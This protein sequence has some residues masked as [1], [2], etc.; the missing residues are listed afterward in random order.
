MFKT[1]MLSYQNWA[2]GEPD[3]SL[4]EW[5]GG[6]CAAQID[7]EYDLWITKRCGERGR[8]GT[9]CEKLRGNECPQGWTF[10]ASTDGPLCYEFILNGASYKAE[11]SKPGLS[12]SFTAH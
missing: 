8:F 1:L 12:V 7:K 9:G 10:F 11:F 3:V 4:S 6:T 2:L 5:P